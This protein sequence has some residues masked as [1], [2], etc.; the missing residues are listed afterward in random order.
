M[1][2]ILTVKAVFKFHLFGERIGF[3]NC[4]FQC[5]RNCCH[6][7]NTAAGA[8]K[9]IVLHFCSG[10]KNVALAVG[11]GKNNREAAFVFD[12]IALGGDN[13]TAGGFLAE[14]HLSFAESALA[15]C[16]HNREQI[17]FQKRQNNLRFRIAEAAVIFDDFR[18][19]LGNHQS[20]IQTASKRSAFIF[21]R[22]DSRQK[23]FFHTFVGDFFCVIRVRCNRSHTAGVQS[24]IVVMG[25]FMIHGGNHRFDNI[26]VR[27][28]KN[29]NLGTL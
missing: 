28:R 27:E 26:S 9:L 3:F 2:D 11:F 1:S 22:F 15:C 29:R 16:L 24:L 7:K 4:T 5:I 23:D 6:A 8:E 20:E 21:H 10:N 14:F 18:T 19:V 13:H 17:T 25:S 12:G